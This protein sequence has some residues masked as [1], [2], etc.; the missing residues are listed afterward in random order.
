MQELSKCI[1]ECNC[2]ESAANLPKPWKFGTISEEDFLREA[3]TGDLLLYQGSSL[4]SKF[5][6]T[7]T[8]GQFDH[9][10]MLLK[11]ENDPHE[12]YL[13]EATSNLGVALN[14]WA[15]QRPYVGSGKFYQKI[16]FR[17]VECDRE[18]GPMG[19]LADFLD[20]AL[21]KKYGIG[22]K[23]LRKE[24]VSKD[25]MQPISD[26]RTFFCSEL[27]VKAW[28]ELGVLE[29]DSI[30]SSRYM[31]CPPRRRHNSCLKLTPGTS[32]AAERQI[33]IKGAV[34]PKPKQ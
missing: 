5:I 6:R 32:I 1:S 27:V 11:F 18:Q 24:T 31:P 13:V 7:M 10:A 8:N 29:N 21:G 14:K 4:N 15:Y 22:S 12:V 26:E 9:V 3:D 20:L 2:S 34:M 28:K 19:R 23:L 25:K 30:S 16:A 17:H 33:V